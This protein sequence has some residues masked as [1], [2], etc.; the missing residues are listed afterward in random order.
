MSISIRQAVSARYLLTCSGST[1]DLNCFNATQPIARATVNVLEEPRPVPLTGI[2]AN[3]DNS[4]LSVIPY[5]LSVSLIMLC[6]MSSTFLTSSIS[7]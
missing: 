5:N 1:I 4:N 2:S 7:E 6:L 3:E